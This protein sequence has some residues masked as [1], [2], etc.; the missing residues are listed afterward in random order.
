M[1]QSG[2]WITPHLWGKPW[3]EK[4][5]LL[6]WMTAL[7]FDA[8][9][10][11]DFAPRLPVALLSVAFLAFYWI[12][13]R[14]EFGRDA[15]W[16]S[17][18]MLAASAGWL[19]YSHVAITDIPLAVFFS[20]AV[21]LSLDWIA[22]GDR[23]QVVLS[24]ACL[25]FAAL[26]KGLVPIVLFLPVVIA[27]IFFRRPRLILDWVRPAPLVAFCVIALPWYVLVTL[28]NGR[29]FIRVFFI[30]QQFSRLSSAAL[31]HVQPWWFYVPIL[32][33]LLFPWFPLVFIP[34]VYS[35]ARS[36]AGKRFWTLL[37]VVIFGFLFFTL[38]IN[39]LPHY[40]LPLLPSAFAVLGI[41]ISVRARPVW[42]MGSVVLLGLLPAAATFGPAALSAHGA[43]A[44]AMPSSKLLAPLLVAAVIG[45]VLLLL[46][47]I[48]FGIVAI[49]AACA[50]IWFQ[51]AAFPAFDRASARHLLTNG[52]PSCAPPAPRDV[53][54]GLYYYAGKELPACAVLDQGPTRVVR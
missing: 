24:A 49:L 12:R 53:I 43:H 27:P 35:Q 51:F 50:F 3:F 23:S 30:E 16:C 45:G 29:D 52:I 21:L 14:K 10:G 25:A 40:L 18:A 22:R 54:Y 7:G 9:L 20:A 28:R 26:A 42:L 17:T 1:A 39:K 19:T 34:P 37:C 5:A 44:A 46:P 47:R 41:G 33:L 15:A 8:G 4:P 11:P 38:S 31:Q 32:L 48:S 13:L 36:M 2:D 6:Y